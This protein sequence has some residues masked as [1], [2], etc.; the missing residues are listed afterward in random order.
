MNKIKIITMKVFNKFLLLLFVSMLAINVSAQEYE[1]AVNSY[2][3]GLEQ[4]KSKNYEAAINSFT[5]ALEIGESLGT[6]QGNSIKGQAVKQIPKMYYQKAVVSFNNFQSSKT[7]TDLDKAVENFLEAGDI[8]KKY[9]DSDIAA[10]STN[11]IP[12][13]YYQKGTLLYAQQDFEAA[14]EALDKAI[15]ANAN[16]AKPYYQKGLVAK[17]IDENDIDNILYWYDQAITVGEAVNDNKVV[18][19]AKK[20]AQDELLYRGVKA[21]EGKRYADAVELLDWALTYNEESASVHY[22]L[23]EVYNKQSKADQ[24]IEH[25]NKALEFERGGK[26]DHAKIY[27]ELGLAYQTKDNKNEACKAFSD[28]LYGSFKAP[29]SHIMEFELK[30]AQASN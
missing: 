27:F 6:D 26:T 12:Q 15:N 19:S 18:N 13:L 30:C 7:V 3:E 10:R 14:N 24:A 29:A 5:K 11:I 17:K 9:D 2:N 8:G 16:Y 25:A 1:D 23:A 28:A 21:S 20:S 22:R 4:A